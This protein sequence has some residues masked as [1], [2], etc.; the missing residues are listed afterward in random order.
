[1][2]TLPRFNPVLPWYQ[3]YEYK[4]WLQLIFAVTSRSHGYTMTFGEG[5]ALA[6]VQQD[7]RVVF[8]NQD[9]PKTNSLIRH[10]PGSLLD[11]MHQWLCAVAAHEAAHVRFTRES[12]K[13]AVVH[14]IWNCIEDER[15]ERLLVQEFPSLR[16][17]FTMMGDVILGRNERI[18]EHTAMEGI[19][20]WRFEHDR[21]S[22]RWKPKE[23][24]AELWEQIRPLVEEGWTAPTSARVSELAYEIADL[25]KLKI[26]PPEE[27]TVIRIRIK[28]KTPPSQDAGAEQPGQEQPSP[29]QD[30]QQ[31]H[32]QDKQP[33]SGQDG[34]GEGEPS[35]N[36][37][38]QG[39]PSS[40]GVARPGQQP[41][42]Q[43]QK[44][45]QG[46]AEQEGEDT[47]E[48]QT[49][50]SKSAP[51][52]QG[53][54]QSAD[55]KE[56]QD[57]R[58]QPVR[59][60]EAGQAGGDGGDPEDQDAPEATLPKSWEGIV[61]ATII[62]EIEDADG[63]DE[64]GLS[65]GTGAGFNAQHLPEPPTPVEVDIS[66]I[67]AKVEGYAMRLAPLLKPDEKPGQATPH[68]SR[69]QYRYD[70]DIKGY[71]KVFV[72]KTVPSRPKDIY[73]D[74]LI[75]RS[76]SMGS[77]QRMETAKTSLIMILK[78]AALSRSR[79][80]VTAF[81]DY[82]LTIID[83]PMPYVEA[84]RLVSGIQPSGGTQLFPALTGILT[85][86][87][88]MPGEVHIV[89]I[90]CD[91]DLDQYDKGRC[92]QLAKEAAARDVRFLPVLI[93]EAAATASSIQT[94]T[95]VFGMAKACP[96]VETV[97]LTLL[98]QLTAIRRQ[99]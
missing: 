4:K 81:D 61:S 14:G 99:L 25:L 44:S 37:A 95:E 72:K 26:T 31:Q 2:L 80:R 73:L 94:W 56:A 24:E 3:Q 98:D 76:G 47:P 46:K 19:L 96:D 91:G 18:W 16:A 30:E 54:E 58:A 93:G 70:R 38:D 79:V 10:D 21:S 20:F 51:S 85:D 39:Q 6:W 89:T 64:S 5:D 71:E 75:D 45:S 32:G 66:G 83:R 1:M 35:Q 7:Q 57:E 43:A 69:G 11:R 29:G 23:S 97:S 77:H 12:P 52:E 74:L 33:P 13:H 90:I 36:E 88:E 50:E 15:I 92:A 55:V 22:P 42:S 27:D 41:D 9:I 60:A 78:A 84:V 82:P 40:P 65:G 49:G 34:Q 63:D 48:N 59:A 67:A 87:P 68:R 62:V 53:D 8:I 17:N 28:R 86:T